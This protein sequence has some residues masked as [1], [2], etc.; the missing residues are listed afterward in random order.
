[1]AGG[2]IQPAGQVVLED[3]IRNGRRG[4]IPVT[5]QHR[6]PVT[7]K[8]FR[9]GPRKPF[10]EKSGIIAD[11]QA[12]VVDFLLFQNVDDGLRDDSNV[13]KRK[14]FPQNG[15]PPRGPKGHV[16]HAV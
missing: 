13:L 3:V 1:M 4:R 16:S 15:S 11:D 12:L 9:S 2:N 14:V 10:T 7:R 8:Y 5:Q 6:Y